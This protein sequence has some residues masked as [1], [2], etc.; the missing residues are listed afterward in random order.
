M[1]KIKLKDCLKELEYLNKH[2]KINTDRIKLLEEYIYL[3]KVSSRNILII[4]DGKVYT[5][6]E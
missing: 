1:L 2:E 4:E 5:L 6:Y 3:M